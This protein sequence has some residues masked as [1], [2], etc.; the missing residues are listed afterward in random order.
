[1][2][3]QNQHLDFAYVDYVPKYPQKAFQGI[4]GD[5]WLVAVINGLYDKFPSLLEQK[6]K[7]HSKGIYHVKPRNQ[8]YV[9][10]P[11]FPFLKGNW[12]GINPCFALHAALIEKSIVLE[13]SK[14]NKFKKNMKLGENDYYALD[15]GTIE[16][17]VNLLCPEFEIIYTEAGNQQPNDIVLHSYKVHSHLY[18]VV[19]DPNRMTLLNNTNII[20]LRKSAL[21]NL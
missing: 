11:T 12:L 19:Y 4:V 13:L 16:Q 3:W 10:T 21:R 20:I 6:I 18:H 17:A 15:G 9:I 1:M 2:K 14:N 7:L 8:E 5:C